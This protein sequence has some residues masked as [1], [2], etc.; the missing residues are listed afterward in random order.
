MT[1]IEVTRLPKSNILI[2]KQRGGRD[3]FISSDNVIV[4]SITALSAIIKY[5]VQSGK[6]SKKVLEGI[7]AELED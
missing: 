5:L 7:L 3:F 1:S 2:L 4:V 6:L